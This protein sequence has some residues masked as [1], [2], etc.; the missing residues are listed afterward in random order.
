[1]PATILISVFSH[2]PLLRKLRLKG[3]PSA[4]IPT[5]LTYLPKLVTLDVEYLGSGNYRQPS[6]NMLPPLLHL[7]VRTCS[8]DTSGPEHLWRW[9]LRLLPRLSLESLTLHSFSMHG[10]ICI[11][12]RF[13]LDLAAVHQ[14]AL[15]KLNM[16][17]TQLT[18]E[19]MKCVCSLFPRLEELVCSVASPDAVGESFS[20][21][22]EEDSD[23]I[24]HVQ[25][26]IGRA[27]AGARNLRMMQLHVQWI[28]PEPRI[29]INYSLNRDD[30]AYFTARHATEIMLRKGSRLRVVGVGPV[31]YTVGS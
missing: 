24:F 11:P 15:R 16:S 18:L 31:M 25:Y 1:V 22:E 14:A 28:P 10:Y 26:S 19:D 7:T 13:V 3:A 17:T 9:I 27:I 5:I 4:A 23:S 30:F 8:M 6:A 21:R 29:S 20:R 2:L 12:R